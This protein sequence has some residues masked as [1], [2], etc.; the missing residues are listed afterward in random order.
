MTRTSSFA[1]AVA[2]GL[3]LLLPSAVFAQA[4][5]AA[6]APAKVDAK[7]C[8]GC[9]EP[10]S[11]GRSRSRAATRARWRWRAAPR[12]RTAT[13]RALFYWETLLRQLERLRRVAELA[14]GRG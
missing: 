12:S 1:G 6:G 14:P 13:T 7:A 3:R 2:P 4:K 9:H 11:T 5:P 8:Y 10:T